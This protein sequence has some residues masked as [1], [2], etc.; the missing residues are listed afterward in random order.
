MLS[1]SALWDARVHSLSVRHSALFLESFECKLDDELFERDSTLLVLDVFSQSKVTR[2]RFLLMATIS[3]LYTQRR[4]A[5]VRGWHDVRPKFK[6][7]LG[8]THPSYTYVWSLF[9][10]RQIISRSSIP[11]PRPRYSGTVHCYAAHTES[12]GNI[13]LE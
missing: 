10:R 13:V 9:R 2:C 6:R 7:S 3:Y 4:Q 8:L 5:M 12:R 11:P 1:A